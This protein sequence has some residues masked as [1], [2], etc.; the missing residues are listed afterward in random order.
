MSYPNKDFLYSFHSALDVMTAKLAS[1]RG[2]Y[3]K[4]DTD[5][6]KG[7]GHRVVKKKVLEDY[8]DVPNA[9]PNTA[10]AETEEVIS[11]RVTKAQVYIW[12]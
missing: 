6:P 11:R 10:S 2:T 7:R 4:P 5:S 12:Q 3:K 1:L 8:V 9:T